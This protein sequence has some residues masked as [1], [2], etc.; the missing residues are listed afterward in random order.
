[1]RLK[2]LGHLTSEGRQDALYSG[3]KL[4]LQLQF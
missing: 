3:G 4:L 1:V 2:P